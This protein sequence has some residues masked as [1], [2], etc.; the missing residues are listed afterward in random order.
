MKRNQLFKDYITTH[1]HANTDFSENKISLEFNT[2]D[3]N[4]RQYLPKNKDAKILEVGFGTGYF[5]KYLLSLGYTDVGGIEMSPEATDFVKTNIYS[6]VICVESTQ[7]YIAEH[8][9]EFDLIIMF[10]VLEHIPK[11]ETIDFLVVIKDGLK[12]GGVF[13]ARVPNASNPLNINAFGSDFTHEFI[14]TAKSL[15]QVNRITKFSHIEIHPFKEEN[16]SLHS[17]VTNITQPIMFF[18]IRILIGLARNDLDPTS[19]YTK[20]IYCVCIK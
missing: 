9:H 3:R 16:I 20:N 19:L 14:H 12:V 2:F 13:I 15:L 10:D 6:N 11:P 17:K 7:D 5:L 1:H 18:I 4:I 8:K